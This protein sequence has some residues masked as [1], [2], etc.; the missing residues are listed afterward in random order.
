MATEKKTGAR[1]E[2]PANTATDTRVSP[3]ADAVKKV[4]FSNRRAVMGPFGMVPLAILLDPQVSHP[5]LRIYIAISYHQGGKGA[6]WPSVETI[7]AEARI[8]TG[9]VSEYTKKLVDCQ[10]LAKRRRY[11]QSVVYA[12]L[13]PIEALIAVDETVSPPVGETEL[14]ASS[15]IS[16]VGGETVSPSQGEL[17]DHEEK[18]EEGMGKDARTPDGVVGTT[19]AARDSE[20]ETNLFGPPDTTGE[21]V[22]EVGDS[23]PSIDESLDNFFADHGGRQLRESAGF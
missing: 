14:Y 20:P 3:V 17:R 8:S 13:V 1:A 21:E 2:Q 16:P 15:T 23:I 19:A 18:K 7:A 22:D 6:A 12:C 4:T 9:H 10:W 11:G 5:M